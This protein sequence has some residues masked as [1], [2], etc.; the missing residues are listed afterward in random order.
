M[1]LTIR[2]FQTTGARGSATTSNDTLT[3]TGAAANATVTIYQDVGGVSHSIGTATANG[4]GA[5]SYTP[6]GL[7]SGSVTFFAETSTLTSSELTFTYIAP[8]ST[9]IQLADDTNG[10]I[11]SDD[12]LDGTSGLPNSYVSIYEDSTFVGTAVVNASGQWSYQPVGL[13][14]GAHSFAAYNTAS[15]GA[16]LTFTYVPC[17]LAG[18]RLRTPTGWVEVQ[19]VV[20]GDVVLTADGAEE[21]VRWVGQ[22]AHD[23]DEALANPRVTPVLIRKGAFAEAVPVQD[24]YVSPDHA[25]LVGG[26]LAQA[27]AL[28]NGNSIVN[29]VPDGE[30]VYYHVE[31]RRHA[32]LLAEDLPAES[33]ID[34]VDRPAFDNWDSR[35]TPTVAMVEMELPR[36]KSWRQ[37][38]R[39]S[40]E[41]LEAR[42]EA[43]FGAAVQAA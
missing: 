15:S 22:H 10:P 42:G 43:L 20:T 17:Y 19:N 6:T 39:R 13:T 23:H 2:L 26:V 8:N 12:A 9:T 3:G 4:S 34:N 35:F 24:L 21:R 14:P 25:V 31:L 37:V 27:Q 5:W 1:A 29:A 16:Q 32:L 18:T 36:A 28:V 41:M 38:P 11:S 30:V 7:A 33:F 40:R